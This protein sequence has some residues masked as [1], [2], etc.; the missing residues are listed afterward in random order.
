LTDFGEI[1]SWVLLCKSFKKLKILVHMRQ[2]YLALCIMTSVGSFAAGTQ[3]SPPKHC[4][5]TGNSFTQ[6]TVTVRQQCTQNAMLPF[7]C[8]NGYANAAQYYVTRALP[9]LLKYYSVHDICLVKFE[10][11]INK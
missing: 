9:V 4:Y 5:A 1:R 2:K 11:T 7:S 6:L 10:G 3:N 8:N